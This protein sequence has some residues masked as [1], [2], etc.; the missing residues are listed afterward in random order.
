MQTL[1]FHHLITKKIT[2][3]HFFKSKC[4]KHYL[5]IKTFQLSYYE[6][7]CLK[8]EIW[9]CDRLPPSKNKK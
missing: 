8:C 9:H 3:H 4:R 7:C 6:N 1:V 2:P 5:I